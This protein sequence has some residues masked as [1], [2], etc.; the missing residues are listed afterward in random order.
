MLKHF[1][2]KNLRRRQSLSEGLREIQF[3]AGGDLKFD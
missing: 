2:E 3:G 1:T